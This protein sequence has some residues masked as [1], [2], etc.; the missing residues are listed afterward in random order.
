MTKRYFA[1]V[2]ISRGARFLGFFLNLILNTTYF[3]SN[4][5]QGLQIPDPSPWITRPK[6]YMYATL[7]SPDD[8]IRNHDRRDP[9]L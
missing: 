4:L 7:E 8:L 2:I 9:H 5:N 3:R 6:F 1:H